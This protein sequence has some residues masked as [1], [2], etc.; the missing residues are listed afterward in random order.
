M[1]LKNCLDCGKEVSTRAWSCPQCGCRWPLIKFRSIWLTLVVGF[2]IS[3]AIVI[4]IFHWAFNKV[5]Y[6]MA[7]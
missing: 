1:A 2:I 4:V 7:P 5:L 6:D 3:F